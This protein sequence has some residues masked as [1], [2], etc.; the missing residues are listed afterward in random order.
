VVVLV[1]AIVLLVDLHIHAQHDLLIPLEFLHLLVDQGARKSGV[2]DRILILFLRKPG[3]LRGL[4]M[5][6]LDSEGAVVVYF[7]KLKKISLILN[8][9]TR[10]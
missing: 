6:M 9:M 4:D 1:D 7:G 2:I 10:S 3:L 5:L 8:H